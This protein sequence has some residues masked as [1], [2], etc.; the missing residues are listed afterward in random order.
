MYFLTG[1]KLSS[2]PKLGAKY[3]LTFDT[4]LISGNTA[5]K[6]IS[7]T[8]GSDTP[9]SFHKTTDDNLVL[10]GTQSHSYEITVTDLT[11]VTNQLTWSLNGYT[12]AG[13]FLLDNIKIEE[14]GVQGFVTKLYDQTGNNCHATQDTAA[15]QPKLVAGGDLITSGGKPAW[16]Y[17]ANT[18]KMSIQGLT[19]IAHLDSLFVTDTSATKFMLANS[20][21]TY[22]MLSADSGATHSPLDSV[23]GS[24]TFRINGDA[25]SG[26]RGQA[27]T[28][29]NGH[30]LLYIL[31]G[32]TTSWDTYELG[33][34]YYDSTWSYVGKM[35][36]TVF[37]DSDQS[38]N[39]AGIESN[40][41]THYT[42]Y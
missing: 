22:F 41:N 38:S 4:K 11:G 39:Q 18:I 16:E 7:F 33:D 20:A 37:W 28:E 35:S 42:I 30:N 23:G 26:H 19:G 12:T 24:P 15:Y 14:L 27:A 6:C 2:T 34:S 5:I 8:D 29:L 17:T 31:S 1:Y 3:R 32:A 21:N 25:F 13:T 10:S 36:E 9:P 40:I